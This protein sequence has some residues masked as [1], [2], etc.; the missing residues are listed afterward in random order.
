VVNGVAA[1]TRDRR[2]GRATA[3]AQNNP[4]TDDNSALLTDRNRCQEQSFGETRASDGQVP[5]VVNQDKISHVFYS[6]NI[7]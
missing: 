6:D 4:S 1:L 5:V 3:P 7:W 2:P